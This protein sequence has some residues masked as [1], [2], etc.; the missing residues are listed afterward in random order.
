[1]A[2]QIAFHLPLAGDVVA[3]GAAPIFAAGFSGLTPDGMGQSGTTGQ[4]ET[5]KQQSSRTLHFQFSSVQW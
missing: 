5:K 3:V 4:G 2:I 1:M